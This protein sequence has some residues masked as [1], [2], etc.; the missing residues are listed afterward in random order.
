[1][2]VLSPPESSDIFSSSSLA[3]RVDLDAALQ[4]MVGIEEAQLGSSSAEKPAEHIVK[5]FL[6]LL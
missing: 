5:F 3:V 6:I 4:H 1:V 2:S